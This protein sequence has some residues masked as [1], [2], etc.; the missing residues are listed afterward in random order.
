M[1]KH[2]MLCKFLK[3]DL[4]KQVGVNNKKKKAPQFVTKFQTGARTEIIPHFV[5]QLQFPQ[6]D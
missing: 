4:K 2:E 6:R 5:M 1:N 3:H